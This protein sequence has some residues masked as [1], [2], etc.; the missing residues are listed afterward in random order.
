MAIYE[1]VKTD[2]GHLFPKAK[3]YAIEHSPQILTGVGLSAVLAA[4]IIAV[5]NTPAACRELEERKLDEGVDNLTLV[6]VIKFGFKYYIVPVG[7]ALIGSTC[8]ISGLHVST[9]RANAFAALAASQAVHI[10][11]IHDVTREKVGEKKAHE[12]D[13]EVAKRE[14]ERSGVPPISQIE[15][16]GHG[17]QIVYWPMLER[18]FQCDIGWIRRVQNEINREIEEG[19]VNENDPY[20]TKTLRG[21][22]L[23]RFLAGLNL[24]K[25]DLGMLLGWNGANKL[26]IK[27]Y[28]ITTDQESEKA[29]VLRMSTDDCVPREKWDSV[30]QD[31][32]QR[33]AAFRFY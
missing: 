15:E 12:I 29:V 19:D 5:R 33:I 13:T 23:N 9:N 32:P 14:I 8:I 22:C 7:M 26:N 2:W 4:G 24:K 21:V 16:T 30:R 10:K 25:C 17:D 1:L 28:D 20:D 6:D 27:F 11:D 3:Q 31:K 18:W